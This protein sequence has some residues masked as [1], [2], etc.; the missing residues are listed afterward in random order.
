M[1]TIRY[2]KD[3]RE[4]Y[5]G[6]QRCKQMT[7]MMLFKLCKIPVIEKI[8]EIVFVEVDML[9]ADMMI[10]TDLR[11]FT[12]LRRIQIITC[13]EFS[14]TRVAEQMTGFRNNGENFQII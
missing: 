1:E 12:K 2:Y 5:A 10:E 14:M 4:A 6:E 9:C 7:A 3:S 11:P 13:R 8:R